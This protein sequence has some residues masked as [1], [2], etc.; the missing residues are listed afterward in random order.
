MNC[1]SSDHV[2]KDIVVM[3]RAKVKEGLSKL[4][5]NLNRVRNEIATR[6]R[7]GSKGIVKYERALKK[8]KK[9]VV[10]IKEMKTSLETTITDLSN[11]RNDLS[12]ITNETV[13]LPEWHSSSDV[14]RDMLSSD[15]STDDEV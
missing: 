11:I 14:D 3:D 1:F 6:V 12:F 4:S 10:C 5:D 9:S 2:P 15:S 7:R 13:D 8:M